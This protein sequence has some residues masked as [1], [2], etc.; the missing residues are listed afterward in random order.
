MASKLILV[1]SILFLLSSCANSDADTL[2][3]NQP[4][5]AEDSKE[6]SRVYTNEKYN[7]HLYYPEWWSAEAFSELE[8]GGFTVNVFKGDASAEEDLPLTVHEEMEYSYVAIW[9]EGLAVE[10]PASHVVP[11]KDVMHSP[12]LNFAIN[13]IES[14]L[15]LLKDRSIWGYFLVP[16][17]PPET[18]SDNG[19]IFAQVGT[20]NVE[21]I[22]YNEKTGQVISLEE[23]DNLEGDRI[24]RTGQIDEETAAII[25]NI[26]E[27]IRLEPVEAKAQ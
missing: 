17:N 16:R 23:C 5:E 8:A 2:N 25:R 14:K 26:L 24:V 4:E 10:L 11:I 19:F 12:A 15:L 13:R 18:W 3:R 9:P 1:V 7:I 22:C 21:V 6:L 20:N 27:N